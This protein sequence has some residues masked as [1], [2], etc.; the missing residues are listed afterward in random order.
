LGSAVGAAPILGGAIESAKAPEWLALVRQAMARL[1]VAG[2][3]GPLGALAGLL[4]PT[5]RSHVASGPIPG[6]A[7]LSF[8]YDEGVLAVGWSD[9]NGDT[10]LLAHGLPGRD[11][12]YHSLDGIAIG[13]WTPLVNCP[14][15]SPSN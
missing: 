4:L 8:R 13:R 15:E 10:R 3:I 9:P 7:D 12:I 2:A 5:N 6:H 1:G 11:G 14:E